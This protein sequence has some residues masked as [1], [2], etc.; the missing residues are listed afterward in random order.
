MGSK[1]PWKGICDFNAY[2]L[3]DQGVARDPLHG[4]QQEA[5]QRHPLTAVVGGDLLLGRKADGHRL[6]SGS[7][8]PALLW[9]A[10][11][12]LRKSLKSGWSWVLLCSRAAALSWQ[13]QNRM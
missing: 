8:S 3:Y 11:Q 7:A 12:T 13:E 2:V 10:G 9:A 5:G 4:L 6:T 1:G